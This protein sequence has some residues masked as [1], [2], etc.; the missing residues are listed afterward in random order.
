MKIHPTAVLHPEAKIAPDVEIGPYCVIGEHVR[1]GSGTRIQSHVNINGWT[2]IGDGC[3]FYPFS[4]IGEP[5]QD[6]KFQGEVSTLRIGSNNIFREFV[7]L[8]RGTGHG[9]GETVI[10]NHNFFM[11]Y[12]HVAHDC[13]IGDHVILANAATL[14]G[15]I[16]IDD[17]AIIGGLS[18][19]HQFVRIGRHAIIGGASAVP[20]DVPPFCNATGNRATLHGLNTTGLKRHRFPDETIRELKHAYRILFRS[21]QLLRDAFTQVEKEIPPLPEVVELTNFLK[22]SQRGFCR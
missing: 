15:H 20:K 19:I 6:L 3:T 16:L 9:G 8:N 14:A 21:G 1:I 17:Y 13:R 11:A 5:P 10:G 18:A 22:N 4:S 12:C 2:E 7:T